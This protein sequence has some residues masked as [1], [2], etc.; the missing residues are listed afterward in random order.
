M[1]ESTML[2]EISTGV[3]KLEQELYVGGSGFYK[4]RCLTRKLESL[5][6]L[7]PIWS[8][9]PNFENIILEFW[10]NCRQRGQV[11]VINNCRYYKL[12]QLLQI[13]TEHNTGLWLTNVVVQF[14][15][16]NSTNPVWFLL[17]HTLCSCL[18][19]IELCSTAKERR[20]NVQ[21][22]KNISF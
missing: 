20:N 21:I 4:N 14:N 17:K 22:T 8:A 11:V 2:L 16:A 15:S 3:G 6:F 9:T 19:K 10:N 12:R 1:I 13:T 7:T 5:S 18:K